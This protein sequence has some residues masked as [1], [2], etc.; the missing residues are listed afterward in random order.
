MTI[1]VGN[2]LPKSI[3]VSFI[4]KTDKDLTY[5]NRVIGT[6]I[7][8]EYGEDMDKLTFIRFFEKCFYHPLL[9]NDLNRDDVHFITSH[10]GP[11]SYNKIAFLK[12][13]FKGINRINTILNWR[14]IYLHI[15]RWIG[16]KDWEPK[17]FSKKAIDS[18]I[19]N[20]PLLLSGEVEYLNLDVTR[21]RYA[22]A[23][24]FYYLLCQ[25]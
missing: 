9:N 22:D 18:Y 2:I 20:H 17:P 10:I 8:L 1:L 15:N 6:N 14:D 7:K 21:S 11:F 19:N 3:Q 16:N 23:I 13:F 24:A 5:Y 12:G 4:D 25:T